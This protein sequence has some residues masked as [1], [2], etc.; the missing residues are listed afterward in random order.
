MFG[1]QAAA[2]LLAKSDHLGRRW[3]RLSRGRRIGLGLLGLLALSGAWFGYR[4]WT[5]WPV[6]VSLR[7]PGEYSALTSSLDIAPDGQVIVA[8]GWQREITLWSV[9]VA[10]RWRCTDPAAGG[11]YPVGE[12]K[13]PDGQ[14]FAAQ[15]WLREDPRPEANLRLRPDRHRPP[16][17]VRAVCSA[18][19]GRGVRLGCV[20]LDSRR[21][22]VVIFDRG[23]GEAVDHDAATGREVARRPITC[24]VP[25]SSLFVL[26]SDGRH[27]AVAPPGRVP[28]STTTPGPP[29]LVWDVDRDRE[30]ARLP[31]GTGLSRIA[32]NSALT[33]LAVGRDDGSIELWD[34]RAGG[35]RTTLRGHRSDFGVMDLQFAPDGATLASVGSFT[36]RSTTIAS[37]MRLALTVGHQPEL[38]VTEYR[39]R[40]GVATG[41]LLRRAR[42]EG[43][44]V[45]SPDGRFLASTDGG[46]I[47]VRTA[48][49]G[50]GR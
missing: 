24:P 43:S 22:R 28:I 47:L 21:L 17:R 32:L 26:S 30:V 5:S 34:C 49:R 6:R 35:L 10:E 23:S 44:P 33:T 42:W 41:Q 27:M 15:G 18:L 31:R 12:F 20:F 4:W 40:R 16:G 48:P 1:M 3:R 37:Q 7:Q 39:A 45:F 2:L 36:G 50:S 38:A 8:T 11:C 13:Y 9:V 46:T 25:M 14:T 19:L 29:I